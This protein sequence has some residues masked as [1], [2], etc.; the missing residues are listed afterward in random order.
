MTSALSLVDSSGWIEY[1]T[2]GTGADFFAPAIEATESL[3]VASLGVYEVFRWILRESGESAAL[4]AT[5][6]MQQ[7]R[8]IG[9]DSALALSAARVGLQYKLPLADSVMYATAR[10]YEAVL[11]T[12]DADFEGLPG[13]QYQPK[14]RA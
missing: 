2:G 9:L 7:G 12:Q 13:V 4:Q 3:L 1:F 10:A 6:L 8:V 5:A 14:H 11:W